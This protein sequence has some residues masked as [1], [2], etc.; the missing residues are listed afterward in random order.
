MK[1][2]EMMFNIMVAVYYAMS[3]GNTNLFIYSI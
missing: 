1:A 2:G 3:L